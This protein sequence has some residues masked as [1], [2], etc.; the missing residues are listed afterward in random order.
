[1]GMNGTDVAR[2]AADFVLMDDNF[3]TIHTAIREGRGIYENIR[4]SV[5]FLLSSNLG[6]IM[7]MLVTIVAGLPSPLKASF[8]LWI[9]LITDS[10]PALAL[11]VDKNDGNALM[12]EPPRKSTDSLF[13]TEGLPAHCAMG[14]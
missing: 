3:A 11:G 2:G 12:K 10:L 4:K 8:I 14:Q 6:E 7:T 5:L 1:M 13:H 9:N